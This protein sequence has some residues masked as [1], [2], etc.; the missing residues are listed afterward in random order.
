MKAE[1]LTLDAS[2]AGSVEL[3]DAVF[4]LEPRADILQRMV[5]YQLSKRQAGTHKAKQRSE[6]GVPTRRF[7]SKKAL[8]ALATVTTSR[9]SSEVAGGR[10]ARYR[11]ATLMTCRR[12]SGPSL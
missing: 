5:R 8:G 1:V 3:S 10:S 7:T 6:V 12:K 4:A 2:A 9:P 11:G